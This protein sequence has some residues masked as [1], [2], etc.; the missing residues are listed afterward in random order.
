MVVVERQ[1]HWRAGEEPQPDVERAVAAEKRLG[2]LRQLPPSGDST[3]AY[4][5][6]LLLAEPDKAMERDGAFVLRTQE[7]SRGIIIIR[8]WQGGKLLR[9]A[10]IGGV[11]QEPDGGPVSYGPHIHFPT[12]VFH[13]FDSRRARSR[14]YDW[15]VPDS[16]S[17]WDAM[18]AFA[19]HINLVGDPEEQQRRLSGGQP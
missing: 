2:P 7:E 5:S 8:L 18:I 19:S 17:L 10:H 4:E 13:T 1:D 14:I 16:I 11:H 15:D 3:D 12:T 6:E 9:R